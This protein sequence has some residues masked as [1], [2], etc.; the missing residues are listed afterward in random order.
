MSTRIEDL[1]DQEYHN[2]NEDQNV[3]N[4]QGYQEEF[5][6]PDPELVYNTI[7]NRKNNSS[8]RYP[9]SKKVK[10]EEKGS[11]LSFFNEENVLILL[12]L[13]ISSRNE[14]DNLILINFSSYISSEFYTSILKCVIILIFYILFKDYLLAKMSL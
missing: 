5:D 3:Y 14:I 11:L 12:M 8:N 2:D 4:N 10:F 1:P 9:I 7:Q 6:E 13:I